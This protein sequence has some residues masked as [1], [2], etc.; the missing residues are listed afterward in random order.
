[1]K[2]PLKSK[3]IKTAITMLTAS[4]TTL[5]MFYSG[6][7]VLEPAAIG[8]AWSTTISSVLMIWLRYVTTTPIESKKQKVE[9]ETK[10]PK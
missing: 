9:N 3:T 1:M 7:L 4:L 8:A 10:D 5:A 2:H 6:A